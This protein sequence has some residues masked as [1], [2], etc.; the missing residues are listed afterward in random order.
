MHDFILIRGII[1]GF[2]VA[3]PVG[4]L[5]LLCIRRTLSSGWRTGFVAMIGGAVADGMYGAITAL[6]LTT[7][8]G[9]FIGNEMW[10]R[11]IGGIFL[12]LI[13][14]RLMRT[15]V[16]KTIE[17]SGAVN[18]W[19]DM[20]ESFVAAAT[21]PMTLPAL[22]VIFAATGLATGSELGVFRAITIAVGV[23]IGFLLWWLALSV[24]V[25][26]MRGKFT[27]TL[28]R[29]INRVAGI[30]IIICGLVTFWL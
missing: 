26:A 14:L 12:M 15:P 10:I 16:A 4:P 6:G 13:G 7:V 30:I 28:I 25:D 18:V 20:A 27:P 19:S 24:F 23:F 3:A 22:V 5:G 1:V 17:Q 9:F 11:T 29:N 2:L 21:N 8:S